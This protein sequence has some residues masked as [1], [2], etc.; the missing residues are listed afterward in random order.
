MNK[1]LGQLYRLATPPEAA[2][3]EIGAAP[4]RRP[5]TF[6]GFV[7]YVQ[8]DP[9]APQALGAVECLVSALD[10]RAGRFARLEQRYPG[11]KRRHLRNGA[12][13]LPAGFRG[14]APDLVQR[15]DSAVGIGIRQQDGEFLT[16][17]TGHHVMVAEYR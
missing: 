8:F 4:A 7:G 6:L 1:R 13:A 17:I 15:A 5:V 3:S 9:V 11:G 2:S 10:E 14:A 16:A 12:V